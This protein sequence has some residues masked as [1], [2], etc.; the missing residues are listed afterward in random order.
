MR[1]FL[2]VLLLVSASAAFAKDVEFE[3]F[4][5]SAARVSSIGAIGYERLDPGMFDSVDVA[6]RA[7]DRDPALR[8]VLEIR[9]APNRV[10]ANLK[11][12]CWFNPY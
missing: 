11:L 1:K 4:G 10:G 7:E 6:I 12:E 9:P 5:A 8:R 2:V 3:E